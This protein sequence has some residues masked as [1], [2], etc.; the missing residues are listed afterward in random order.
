LP[1]EIVREYSAVPN[2]PAPRSIRRLA[3]SLA[4]EAVRAVDVGCGYM[5]GTEVL[6]QHHEAVYAVDTGRQRRRIEERLQACTAQ[7]GFRGFRTID[8]FRRSQLRL[9]VAYLIN[10]IH[11]LPDPGERVDLLASIHRNLKRDGLLV[12]DVP[13]SESYYSERMTAENE[14]SDGFLF[15]RFGETFT[16]YR[17]CSEAELDQ[18]AGEAGFSFKEKVPEHHHRVRIYRKRS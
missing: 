1:I 2:R 18:W 8:E 16:F 4:R 3:P 14:F 12:I 9:G 11:T 15:K 13:A 7:I 5:R 6:L 17:F 10:V